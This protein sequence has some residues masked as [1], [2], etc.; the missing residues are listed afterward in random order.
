MPSTKTITPIIGGNYY[1]IF[2]RGSN[3]QLVFFQ[4]RNYFYFL[5]LM[6]KY[7]TECIDILAYCLLPN[8]FHL[9]IRA[10]EE[11]KI[12]DPIALS[13]RILN[14]EEIGKLISDQ[15]RKLFIS[16]TQAINKQENRTGSLFNSKFKRLEITQQEYLEYVIFYVHYNPEKHAVLE[17]F[18]EYNFSSYNSILSNAKTNLNRQLT[19]DVFEG[20]ANFETFHDGWHTE[21][22]NF[23]LE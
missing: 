18:R 13:D 5:N 21:K 16:Y 6:R 19:L 14:E 9:V 17:N 20:K 7:L 8:H 10:K 11:I 4:E 12:K 22:E 2:N 3:H 23:I 1:H 15:F